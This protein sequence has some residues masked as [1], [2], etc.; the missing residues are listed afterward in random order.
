MGQKGDTYNILN[1]KDFLKNFREVKW[2]IVALIHSP[3]LPGATVLPC[4]DLVWLCCGWK[5]G[6]QSAI[7]LWLAPFPRGL[8]SSSL[9]PVP[10]RLPGP[11]RVLSVC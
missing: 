6:A 3:L 9:S 11:Q 8:P 10:G 1:K 7:V 4:L 2:I 5:E